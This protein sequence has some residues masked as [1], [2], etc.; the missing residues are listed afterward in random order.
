MLGWHDKRLLKDILPAKEAKAIEKA[1]GYTTA[2]E[3]LGHHVRKYSHHGSGVGIGDAQEG[4]LVTVVGEVAVAKQS[5]TQSGK[6]LYKV[7][8]LTETE[9]IGISFFGAKHIPRLLPEGT[10]ALFTGKVRYYR[11]EPQLSHPEFIVIPRP[12][13]GAKIT[14]TG[15]MKSLAAYGDVEDVARRLVDREYIPIY[16]GTATMTT[17]RIMAAVQ[18]VLETMPVIPEP[19]IAV[20]NG[21]PS[22][23]EAIRG[24]HDPGDHDPS[25]FITRLKYNE[26]LSLATVMAIRRADTK[27]RKAPPMP[28]ALQGHQ[29]MLIDALNFQLT[30]GQKQVI[31]E[32]SSD[33]E[34]RTPMS[35]LLQGEVGSGK[36]IVSLI[37][38]LQAID[39]GRQCAMLAPTEVL[40]TQHARSLSTTLNNAGLDVRV[41]LLTGSMSTA[42]KR[43]ALLEIVAGNADIVVGT[44]AIIQDTVEFFDL[45]LVVV[46]E[47]H[48]FGVE[49]RDRLRT[50]GREG[51]TPHLLVMTA[52]P[53]P[54]TIAMTVFGDLSVSTLRELP[55]GRR[56]IQTSVIPDYKPGWVKRGWERI[57]EEVLAGRQAYVVCPRI[58]G[59]GGVLEMHAY[60]A[61]EIFPGLNVA[62]LH[63][64][65]DADLKDQV[66]AEFAAGEIDVLVATTVIEVGIDVANATVMLIRE[67]ERFGVSQIHQLRGRVGRGSHDSLC[68]LHTTFD[69]HSPQGQRLTA[70]AATT[71]G[72]QLSELDL[73]VRQ[74]GDVL[75]T[76]QSGSDTKLRHLSFITDQKIIERALIDAAELVATDRRRAL[77]L[78]SE[79]AMVNQEYLEKS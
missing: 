73:Q 17:W 24:I 68:L 7:T 18:R 26:A 20:P 22:F 35:R 39:S 72:F 19:L 33:I 4:D 62:M 23:D 78:V 6:L 11:N 43:E 13:T 67:A 1:L 5:F 21:L 54:R 51:L 8:V 44:H 32:I 42:A 69:E 71:D 46:D 30:D 40:A 70:I 27:N 77:E 74:E 37:A 34:Q 50:K 63:G 56:P 15:G 45:G 12:G 79:I 25:T 38:M 9:R 31:R 41:V 59:E 60:L 57:G 55:G 53:I 52:T 48:R 61:T 3:L 75:G 76:R 49:Q 36:T 10:R 28:R 66:M 2:E 47:Q 14:A 64:R 58:E 16:A 29:H 65:M